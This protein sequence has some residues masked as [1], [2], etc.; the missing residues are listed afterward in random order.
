MAWTAT[1]KPPGTGLWR[2]VK[3]VIPDPRQYRSFLKNRLKTMDQ[4]PLTKTT[5]NQEQSIFLQIGAMEGAVKLTNSFYDV[6]S[7]LPIAKK[8]REMH[9]KDLNH[10]REN[11]T[12]FLSGWLGGPPLYKEKF[13]SVNLTAIH[14]LLEIEEDDKVVW[15]HCMEQA[16]EQ[17]H[18][19]KG[20]QAS[21]LA[22]FQ[23]PADKIV[24]FSQQQKEGIAM[25]TPPPKRIG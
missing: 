8:I 10:T 5:T 14:S 4:P 12:L 21:L 16:L 19:D 11:F 1:V 25:H 24:Q 15:L 22:R 13:G 2:P 18:F 3:Q 9:P 23:M 17:Q 6:M 20:L 7:E